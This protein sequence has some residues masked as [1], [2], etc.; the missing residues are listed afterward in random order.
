M[1][2][3]IGAPV[4][5]GVDDDVAERAKVAAQQRQR[6]VCSRYSRHRLAQ[7]EA[8]TD[9]THVGR[10]VQVRAAVTAITKVDTGW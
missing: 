8:Q 2:A 4:V 10:A 9:L 6:K 1:V 3:C 5:V 7:L